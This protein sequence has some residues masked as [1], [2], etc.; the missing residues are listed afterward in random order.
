MSFRQLSLL[1]TEDL[2]KSQ[3]N[4]ARE[5]NIRINISADTQGI[6]ASVRL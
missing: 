5:K 3:N 2:Q 4:C 6:L 1:P